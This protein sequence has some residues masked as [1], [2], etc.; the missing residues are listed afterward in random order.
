MTITGGSFVELVEALRN[1][2]FLFL[3]DVKWLKQP[4]K[5]D[6]RWTCKVSI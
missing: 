2:G 6:G 1:R 4:N 5:C 3:A